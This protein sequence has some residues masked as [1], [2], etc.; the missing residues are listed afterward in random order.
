[1]HFRITSAGAS[2]LATALLV[3][4]MGL[5]E[6]AAAH[7]PSPAAAAAASADELAEIV[8]TANHREEN[9]QTV[10]IAITA[11]SGDAANKLGVTNLESLGDSVPG[12]VFERQSNGSIP[13]LRGVG[14]P[15]STSGDEPSV[16]TYVDDVY[17]P[18]PG[19][20]TSNY[21]S[22]DRLEIEKGPQG[23]QFGRNATG[24]VT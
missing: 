17:L 13:F 10:P 9:N 18:F 8:V 3:G 24:G 21:N 11:I 6:R 15:N 4:G 20:G 1:M 7:T 12:A 23:T 5:G 19:A 2:L 16:A 22:I 14:N